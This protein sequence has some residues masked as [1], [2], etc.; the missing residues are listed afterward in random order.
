MFTICSI[1]DFKNKMSNVSFGGSWAEELVE[2]EK[3]RDILLNLEWAS[4][5]CIDQDIDTE[6]VREALSYIYSHADKGP[7]LV[8]RWKRGHAIQ[9]ANMR[10]EHFA[11][12]YRL[13][14]DQMG[15]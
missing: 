8:Q 5:N 6:A 13:I 12:T 9:I 11:E 2:A 1:M 10:K 14:V 7:L 15:L 3:E 4:E